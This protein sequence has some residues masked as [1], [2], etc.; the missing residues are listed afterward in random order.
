VKRAASEINNNNN[1]VRVVDMNK[2]GKEAVVEE[3]DISVLEDTVKKLDEIVRDMKS[4]NGE[5]LINT[6]HHSISI[7]FLSDRILDKL[8]VR[9]FTLSLDSV[10]P[11]IGQCIHWHSISRV[12]SRRRWRWRWRSSCGAPSSSH[13]DW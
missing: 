4:G 3:Q 2:V 11:F 5:M 7:G 9:R 13:A 10:H 1:N 8:L 12:S 6:I